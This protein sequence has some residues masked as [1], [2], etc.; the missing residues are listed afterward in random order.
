MSVLKGAAII[1]AKYKPILYLEIN[2][3]ALKQNDKS[4]SDVIQYLQEFNYK[5]YKV[6]SHKVDWFKV[7][8]NP[9]YEKIEKNNIHNF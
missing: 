3:G 7:G 9:T 8:R 5:F 2:H 6:Q 4:L 1:L